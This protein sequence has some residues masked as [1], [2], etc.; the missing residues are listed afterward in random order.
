MRSKI[1]SSLKIWIIFYKTWQTLKFQIFRF[2][3]DTI[4]QIIIEKLKKEILKL[5]YDLY[6]VFWFLI[7]KK[8]KKY[9]FVNAVLKIHKIIIPNA[10][11]FFFVNDF[12][13]QFAEYM[14][15]FLM[16]MFLEYNQFFLIEIFRNLTNFQTF[17]K[18]IRMTIFF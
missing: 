18:L 3:N 7:K 8:S 1:T 10:N 5:C 2:L 11:L 9:K 6:K 14:M 4:A 17:V 16:N 13:K 15:I 12:L